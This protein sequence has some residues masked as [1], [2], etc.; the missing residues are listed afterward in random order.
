MEASVLVSDR[1]RTLLQTDATDGV[2]DVPADAPPDE[3]LQPHAGA[4]ARGWDV[5]MCL[6]PIAF[7]I[8]TTLVKRLHM[9]TSRSLPL[10]AVFMWIIRLSYLKLDPLYTNAAVVYGLFNALTPLSIIAGAICLFQAME[11]TKV[12]PQATRTTQMKYQSLF[13]PFSSGEPVSS[14]SPLTSKPGAVPAMDDGQSPLLVLRPPRGR[15]VPHWL[16]ICLHD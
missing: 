13:N 14:S 15:S 12:L 10:A 4:W 8:T 9:E 1:L 5:F 2:L 3:E 7:L 16:G 11:Q 6:L